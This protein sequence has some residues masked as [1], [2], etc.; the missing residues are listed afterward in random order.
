[1]TKGEPMRRTI[2]LA[3]WAAGCGGGSGSNNDL[4][5]ARD[6]ALPTQ[7][8]TMETQDLAMPPQATTAAVTTSDYMGNTGTLGTIGLSSLTVTKAI[9]TTLVPDNGIRYTGGK[10]LV[11]GRDA[12]NGTVRVYD[13][14]SNFANPTE[15]A[16]G[17]N[18]NPH[19]VAVIPSKSIA[20]VTLYNNSADK[21]VGVIDLANPSAGVT[22]YIGLPKSNTATDDTPEANDIYLCGQ[23]AYVTVQDLDMN[24]APTG[25][26][27]IIAIDTTTDAQDAMNGVIQLQGPNPNGV[28][29]DGTGCDKI[30]VADSGNQFGPTDGKGGVERADLTARMS[31]AIVI[32]DTAL[33][34]HPNGISE[35]KSTMAFAVLTV[36]SGA[37]S[38]VVAI[39]PSTGMLKGPVID[40]VGYI[41]FAQVTPDGMQLFIGVSSPLMTGPGPGVYAGKADG[42]KLTG[43]ALDL[44]QAPNAIAFY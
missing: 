12:A 31:V 2:I 10:L 15:I 30:L 37:A 18:S 3:L 6:M 17:A 23:Y 41:P 13:P 1:M 40:D 26:G 29:R 21:A 7:D 20:Y 22:K 4:A 8:L 16:T 24:F 35:A 11:I 14:K 42:T 39:D 19:D 5:V 36:N 27:R 33:G 9:D 25:N 32:S 34:G 44:G 28:T 38:R 43:T